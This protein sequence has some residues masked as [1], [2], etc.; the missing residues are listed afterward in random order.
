MQFLSKSL[1]LATVVGFFIFQSCS[2]TTDLG[3][4]LVELERS[5]IIYTDTLSLQMEV[6]ESKAISSSNPSRWLV[7]YHQDPVFGES[8][9]AM[10]FNFRISTSNLNFPNSTFDSLVLCL[11]YDTT[12]HLGDVLSNNPSTQ[13]WEVYRMEESIDPDGLYKN[14]TSFTTGAL[15]ASTQFSPRYRDSVMIDTIKLAPHLR[16][17][18]D[19]NL[20]ES[21]LNPTDSTIYANN[22]KFKEFLKGLHI[23]STSNSSSIIRFLPAG[24]Q[25]RMILYY[26]QDV[27]GVPTRKSFSFLVN[28][29]IESVLTTK[30]NY[31]S[32]TV[33]ANSATDSLVYAQGLNG[34]LVKTR[35][36]TIANL[37]RIVVNKAELVFSSPTGGSTEATLPKQ[38]IAAYFSPSTE[39]YELVDD[40]QTSLRRLSSYALFG[41]G[42]EADN[43]NPYS[44]KMN[45]S[46]FFQ[47]IVDNEIAD[48]SVY[49]QTLTILEP[50]QLSIG[51]PQSQGFK[52]Q[53]R[54]T[55]TKVD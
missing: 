39:K 14:D 7:G 48:S 45:L 28:E 51:S 53:L 2:K 37:G 25:T 20:G 18:L 17:R 22:N 49:L 11:Q 54:L 8:E 55:Y 4:S 35:F 5:D 41:G 16:I 40:L 32:G 29:D 23:K 52:P 9:A 42:L 1:L 36:P 50:H 33:L 31:S 43:N 12:G 27:D 19:D 10:Y 6:V 44:Y 46:Q 26:T 47:K 15:L 30:H 24:A 13:E 38:M 21:L 3:L 34:V